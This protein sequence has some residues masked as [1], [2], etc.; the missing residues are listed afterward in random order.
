[1]GVSVQSQVLAKDHRRQH[2]MALAGF[3]DRVAKSTHSLCSGVVLLRCVYS[4]RVCRISALPQTISA[5]LVF[6][7]SHG[8][9]VLLR[10]S[11]FP[12]NMNMVESDVDFSALVRQFSFSGW[13]LFLSNIRRFLRLPEM[14]VESGCLFPVHAKRRQTS[15]FGASKFPP[16]GF[17][18]L[19]QQVVA[20]QPFTIARKA[21]FGMFYDSTGL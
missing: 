9:G 5:G 13:E 15:M 8:S 18:I 19:V 21:W 11:L 7:H 14:L 2:S 4:P 1:M 12:W 20:C 3:A 6:V 17:R 16:H 10:S